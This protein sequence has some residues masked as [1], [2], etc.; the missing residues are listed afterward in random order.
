MHPF[1]ADPHPR[2]GA[3]A[4]TLAGQ[5]VA[6][7]R[8]AHEAF[9]VDV[10]QIARARPLVATRRLARLPRRARD[11]LA[12]ERPPD[13]R[14]RMAGLHRRSIAAPKRCGVWPRRYAP[15][16]QLGAAAASGAAATNDPRDSQRRALMRAAVPSS[17]IRRCARTNGAMRATSSTV[18]VGRPKIQ[19]FA[20]GGRDDVDRRSETGTQGDTGQLPGAADELDYVPASL[21]GDRGLIELPLTWRSCIASSRL[22][23]YAAGFC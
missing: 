11:P 8:E 2:L 6:W 22:P 5:R 13:G 21:V 23:A 18:T 12:R 1:V 15:A 9:A 20:F 17:T 3:A 4:V 7:A 10:E 16:R 19:A 14:V